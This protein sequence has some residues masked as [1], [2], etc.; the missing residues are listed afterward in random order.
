MALLFVYDDTVWTMYGYF[1]FTSSQEMINYMTNPI[2]I[3]VKGKKK[4]NLNSVIVTFL[5][6]QQEVVAYLCYVSTNIYIL[7]YINALNSGRN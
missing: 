1:L 3:S 4:S 2:E 7:M 6:N 5:R